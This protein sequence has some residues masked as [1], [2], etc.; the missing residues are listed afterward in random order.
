MA[1]PLDIVD[2]PDTKLYLPKRI[3]LAVNLIQAFIKNNNSLGL[4]IAIILS[5]ARERIDYDKDN[6]V[7]F[8]V[9][10]L[11]SL[12][13]IDREYLSNHLRKMKQTI[14]KYVDLD[15]SVGETVPL[16][17]HQYTR[18]NK[19]IYI[20]VSSRARQLFTEL[21][22]RKEIEGFRFTQAI[23]KNLMN[24]DLR[25]V[26]KHTLKMQM[27]LEMINSFSTVKRKT[28]SLAEINGY[29]GTKYER[30]GDIDRKILRKIKID[31]DIYSSISFEYSPKVTQ[32]NKVEAVIIDV[33][34]NTNLLTL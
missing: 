32:N 3:D 29:F 5:G 20:E 31:T 4:K 26:S 34:D 22:S 24:L 28:M 14:Y 8:D 11:C 23:S 21:S 17:S 25:E 9:D 12:C 33:I 30:Y 16:H 27:L 2:T 1:S 19:Y 18:D 10:E 7:K 15:G 13:R 6:R